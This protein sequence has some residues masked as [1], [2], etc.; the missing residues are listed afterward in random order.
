MV[1]L[2][3]H[4]IWPDLWY[5]SAN[6]FLFFFMVQWY[7]DILYI[8]YIWYL[9]IW[10]NDIYDIYIYIT[11]YIYILLFYLEGII[12]NEN[13]WIW[14]KNYFF[15]SKSQ[16]K[17]WKKFQRNLEIHHFSSSCFTP[18]AIYD[19]NWRKLSIQSAFFSKINSY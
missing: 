15:C 2:L 1:S 8:W 9:Y 7:Y 4:Y 6:A 17:G 18:N 16:H 3:S 12:D 5:N 11:I 13:I 10:Y 14:E 19:P